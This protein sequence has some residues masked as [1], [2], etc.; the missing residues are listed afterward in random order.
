MKTEDA[1]KRLKHLTWI[2]RARSRRPAGSQ[3]GMWTM[4]T[5]RQDLLTAEALDIA[6]NLIEMIDG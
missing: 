3:N 6:I 5:K 2:Y 1:L 4:E